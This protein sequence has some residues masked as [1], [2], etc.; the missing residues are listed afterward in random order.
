M[1]EDHEIMVQD[2]KIVSEVHEIMSEIMH[3]IMS[4]DCEILNSCNDCMNANHACAALH[5]VFG[6]MTRPP[7]TVTKASETGC[8]SA[9]LQCMG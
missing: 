7:A 2:H 8:T 3:E 1:S 9:A 4:E 6:S 5:L